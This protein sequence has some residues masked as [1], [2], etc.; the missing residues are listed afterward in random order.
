MPVRHMQ[1]D[2]VP[3]VHE[4]MRALWPDFEGDDAAGEQVIVWEQPGGTLGGFVSFSIRPRA[5]GSELS[6]VPYVEGWWVAPDLR[7]K[8]V[9]RELVAAVERWAKMCGFKEL[10]SDADHGNDLGRAAHRALGFEERARMVF[11]RKKLK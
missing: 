9:G 2:D 8:G 4:M 7:R 11:F 10:C 5:E 6:P 3:A 1:P